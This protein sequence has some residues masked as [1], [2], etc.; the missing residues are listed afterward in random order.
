[1]LPITAD[2]GIAVDHPGHGA[3]KREHRKSPPE[4]LHLIAKLL[5]CRARFLRGFTA[6]VAEIREISELGRLL[7]Y[8]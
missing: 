6:A 7:L 3:S 2:K 8:H 1:V 4:V 5:I